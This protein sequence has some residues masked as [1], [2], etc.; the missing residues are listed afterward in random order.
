MS[1]FKTLSTVFQR[2]KKTPIKPKK[3]AVKKPKPQKKH[4][5]QPQPKQKVVVDQNALREAEAR[6]REVIIEAKDQALKIRQKAEED[7]QKYRARLQKLQSEFDQKRH[8]I[9]KEKAV[10]QE[11]ERFINKLEDDATKTK[12]EVDT[13]RQHLLEKLEEIASLSRDEAKKQILSAYEKRLSSQIANMVR[14]AEEKAKEEADE[15]AQEILIDAMKHG[16]TDYVAEYTVST[17]KLSDDDAKGRI[18]GKDGR[19]IRAFEKA[20]GVDVDLDETP[21]EVRISSFDSVRREIAKQSLIKLLRDGRIQPTRVEEVVKK[22]TKDIEKIMF[23]EGKKLCHA[24]GAYNLPSELIAMLGRFKYRSSYGQNMIAHTLEETKI[25]IALAQEVGAN[26]DTVRLGCLLHDIGKVAPEEEGSHVE[27]GVN[28]LKKYKMSQEVVDAVAQHHED[29]PFSSNE[30]ILV[31]VA[32]A[33]S[34]ARPGARYEN[35]E[36]Y[37][38]RLSKLEEISTS[39]DGVKES[40]ALQA[41]REVRVI[42][43]PQKC[44]DDQAVKLASDIR[45]RIKNEMTYPGTV[46]VNVIRETRASQVAK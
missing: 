40:F 36:E 25:G 21:G 3:K 43:N 14:D 46:T 31:Y 23:E 44:T 20:T 22:T 6:A 13:L 26:V 15:K 42:V 18:I 27:L 12:K 10:L 2:D 19:N 4:K 37:V 34:G 29:E 1:L 17:V 38:K 24:V 16:A 11:K 33:I 45:D 9:E 39:F 28:L 32:D 8:G 41:G 30:S 35:Y 5:P 7:V